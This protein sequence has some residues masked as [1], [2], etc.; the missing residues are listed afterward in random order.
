[1]FGWHK[2]QT[3][4]TFWLRPRCKETQGKNEATQNPQIASV[5]AC[6][7]HREK[8]QPTLETILIVAACDPYRS[9]RAPQTTETPLSSGPQHGL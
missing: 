6:C 4:R 2:A 7:W 9:T 8:V 3:H 1:M 5:D